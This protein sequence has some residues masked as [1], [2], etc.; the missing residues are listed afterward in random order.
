MS[1]VKTYAWMR[2]LEIIFTSVKNKQ[3]I[4]FGDNWKRGGID[5][6][7]EVSG[8]KYLSTMKDRFIVRI[9]NLTYK[10]ITSLISGQ[11]YQIEIK[12]GYRSSSIF[13]VFKGGVLY[14]SNEL[15]DRKTNTVIVICASEMVS[16]YGQA[17]MNLSLKSGVNMYSAL[18]YIKKRAGIANAYID[19]DFKQLILR[20][21]EVANM[22]VTS[23]LD[24]ICSSNGW[25][26]NGDYSE[27]ASFSIWNPYRRDMRRIKLSTDNI[28]LTGGYPTLDS[29]GL[30]ISLMP[31]FNFCPGDTIIVDNSIIDIGTESEDEA[32]KNVGQFLDRDGA[33]VITQIDVTLENRGS[34]FS[35]KCQARAKSLWSRLLGGTN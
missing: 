16:R 28:I 11:F 24:T 5:L 20:E 25:V 1:K 30:K 15:G 33:Y 7:I 18:D 14:I 8:T 4:V 17:R 19:Q 29:T 3:R 9:S 34:S 22:N 12:A 6:N 32:L 31:T 23:W 10:E 21:N 35:F 2:Q 26:I 13:T 27:G